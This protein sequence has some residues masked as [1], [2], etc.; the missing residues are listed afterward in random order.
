MKYKVEFRFNGGAE[1]TIGYANLKYLP[2]VGEYLVL[3]ENEYKVVKIVYKM[4]EGNFDIVSVVMYL[5]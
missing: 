4:V 1:E 5:E 3:R 2:R